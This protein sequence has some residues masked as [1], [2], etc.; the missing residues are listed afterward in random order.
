MV[1]MVLELTNRCTGGVKS[2]SCEA[3]L[4]GDGP[5]VGFS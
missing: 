4:F 2:D 3:E 1:K 5:E